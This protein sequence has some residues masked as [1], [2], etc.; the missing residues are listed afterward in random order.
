MGRKS[1]GVGDLLQKDQAMTVHIPS[2]ML[3]TLGIVCALPVLGLA[4]WFFWIWG[5]TKG[6]WKADI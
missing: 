4:L 2:W 3:W 1:V 5:A 6:W